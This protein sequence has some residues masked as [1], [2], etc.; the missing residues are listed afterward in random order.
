MAGQ[1]ADCTRFEPVLEK[2]RVP[3]PARGRPR[4]KPVSL[5]A[6]KAYSSGPRRQ[7]LRRR[8]I[9]HSIPEKTDSQAAR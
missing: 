7:Y 4:K 2:I 3:R 5:A 8:G 9:R 1:R 6:G